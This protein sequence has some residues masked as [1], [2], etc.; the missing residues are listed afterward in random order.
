VDAWA[1]GQEEADP[2]AGDIDVNLAAVND[3][4]FRFFESHRFTFSN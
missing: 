4:S 3:A 1:H 2:L